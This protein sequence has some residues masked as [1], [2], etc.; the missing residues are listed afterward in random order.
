M[1]S[2]GLNPNMRIIQQA[3]LKGKLILIRVDHNVVKKG[4]IKDPYRIDAT[5]KTFNLIL[6]KGGFP[7]AMTHVGRPKDKKNGMISCKETESVKPITEYLSKKLG[8]KIHLPELPIDPEKG[9]VNID[10]SIQPAVEELKNGRAGMIYLPNTRWFWGEQSKGP[11]KDI[12]A[13]ELSE[14]AD[15]FVNDAF[16]SWQAHVSTY[17]I[18]TKLPSYAGLL[19]QKEI[20]NLNS[21]F[22]PERPF[23]GV[24][25]GAKYDTKIGPLKALYEKVD[26]LILGG[27]LYNTFLSLKYGF[28]ISGVPEED[29]AL[30][31]ELVELDASGQK[32]LDLKYLVESDIP[33][34][35][36]EGAYQTVSIDDLSDKKQS[37]YLFDVDPRS[38]EDPRVLKA[39]KS[40]KTF[41]VNAVMGFM[42]YF[43]EGSEALYRLISSNESALKL[44]GG[45]DTLQEF[46]QLCNEIYSAG[47]DS[48]RSYYFTGGGSVLASIEQGTP[49]QLKPIKALLDS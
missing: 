1:G 16:G 33:D 10:D 19:L 5:L 29:K 24:I 8:I 41:F 35:R 42:P 13:N 14:I 34:S 45:G 48:S 31:A 11:E 4:E 36:K 40:A 30:A 9:I 37:G 27:I 25:A 22:H 26:Y 38:F 7:I 20:T 21:L 18:A 44:F 3:D 6:E 28:E 47:L 15:L 12:F 17:D 46:K 39:I 23:I 43:P 49:Y 2:N 32:I